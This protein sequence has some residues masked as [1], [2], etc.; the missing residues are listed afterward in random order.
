MRVGGSRCNTQRVKLLLSW[1]A[2]AGNAPATRSPER[3]V[4]ILRRAV[5]G[6]MCRR[7]ADSTSCLCENSQDRFRM[8]LTISR[9]QAV[10]KFG[11]GRHLRRIKRRY[12]VECIL[13]DGRQLP[14]ESRVRRHSRPS[15]DK[16][17]QTLPQLHATAQHQIRG[18]DGRRSRDGRN[19][20]D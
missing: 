12:T 19:A 9:L 11:L 6:N 20:V 1:L 15:L 5:V 7:V 18:H 3:L 16:C 2:V 4:S 10:R 14:H 17:L 8:S 13:F